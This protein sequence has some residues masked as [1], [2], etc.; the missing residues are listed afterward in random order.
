MKKELDIHVTA[1]DINED[2]I[3]YALK[4]DFEGILCPYTTKQTMAVY[5]LLDLRIENGSENMQAFTSLIK[6]PVIALFIALKWKKTQ[7]YFYAQSLVFISFLLFYSSLLF[8]LFNRP[9]VYCSK[10]EKLLYQRNSTV[11]N[12]YRLFPEDISG[13][14]KE[15][16]DCERY[17]ARPSKKFMTDFDTNFILCEMFFLIF[18]V[19]LSA[20]EIYQAI[21]LRKQYFKELENY[22]EWVVLISAL[23]TMVF[24]EIILQKN[25]EAAV[26]R[27]ITALGICAA[28]LE[29][30]F[31]IGRYS[32]RGGDFSIMF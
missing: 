15:R 11:I 5:D 16:N 1:L 20:M 31:L 2:S 22:I 25:S 32:F 27:G 30:I 21:K 26:I 9:E 13:S 24:M 8:Y 6:H 17:A 18:F 28:W 29:L 14:K 19:F 23:I 12:E 7:W 3:N 10:L 4:V